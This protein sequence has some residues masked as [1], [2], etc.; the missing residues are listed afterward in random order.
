MDQIIELFQSKTFLYVFPI[1]LGIIASWYISKYFAFRKP[2]QLQLAMKSKQTDFGNNHSL[3]KK[4][5]I[6][7]V[8]N[9][10]FGSWEIHSNGTII[11]T[12]H[13]LS[14]IQ[15]PWGTEWNGEEFIGE[16]L[17]MTWRDASDLFGASDYVGIYSKIR[18]ADLANTPNEGTYSKGRCTVNF[19]GKDDWR[20]PTA[21]ELATLLM[22][23]PDCSDWDKEK[24]LKQEAVQIRKQLFPGLEYAPEKFT[25]WTANTASVGCA[26]VFSQLK[27]FDDLNIGLK[28]TVLFVRNTR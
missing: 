2:S 7:T 6:K 23:V 1:I 8:G 12:A 9:D 20:L 24:R 13:N 26:W 17:A 18:P 22:D 21:F 4:N 27:T 16:P 11:D 25:V 19:A 14:W 15:A 3:T 28:Y 10:V 5:T